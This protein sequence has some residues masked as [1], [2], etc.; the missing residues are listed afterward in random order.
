MKRLN[1]LFAKAVLVLI[2]ISIV[3]VLI[4]G[5]HVMGVDSRVLKNEILQK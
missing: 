5:Y 2:L 4:I 3:P 1:G